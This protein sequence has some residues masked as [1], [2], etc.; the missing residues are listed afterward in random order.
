MEMG[1]EETQVVV[2]VVATITH[3]ITMGLQ[4]EVK[5]CMGKIVLG[6]QGIL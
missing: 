4:E 6:V 5:E 3:L 2:V 1:Q